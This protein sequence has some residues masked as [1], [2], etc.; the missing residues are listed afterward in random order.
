MRAVDR[1][2]SVIRLWRVWIKRG[3]SSHIMSGLLEIGQALFSAQSKIF[4]ECAK[5]HG[6]RVGFLIVAIVFLTFAAITFH[7]VLWAL[8]SQLCH[9]SALLSA[10]CV[11]GVDLVFFFIFLLLGLRAGRPGLAEARAR[12]EREEKW[13]ELKQTFAL[14]ALLGV[15]GGPVGRFVGGQAWRFARSMFTRRKK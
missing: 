3:G 2:I 8:F 5:R 1:L 11:L 6:L 14:T 13:N 7:A 4:Q 12:K 9:L 15:A 10:V